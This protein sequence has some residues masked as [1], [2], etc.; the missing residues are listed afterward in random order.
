MT[1]TDATDR[2]WR[3]TVNRVRGSIWSGEPS[4]YV[5]EHRGPADFKLDVSGNVRIEVYPEN[6]DF[7]VVIAL[8]LTGTF[9]SVSQEVLP[10]ETSEIAENPDALDWEAARGDLAIKDEPEGSEFGD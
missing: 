7:E 10:E 6:S 2:T 3:T 1:D 5:Y 4:S 9:H 8:H